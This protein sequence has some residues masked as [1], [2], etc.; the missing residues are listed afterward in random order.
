MKKEKPTNLGAKVYRRDRVMLR[1]VA[2]K[3]KCSQSAVVRLGI[4][5]LHE[6]LFTDEGIATLAAKKD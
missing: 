4:K 5:T 2:R 6:N 3:L 1:K